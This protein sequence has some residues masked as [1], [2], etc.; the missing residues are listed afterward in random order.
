MD[1]I[2]RAE[3]GSVAS[4]YKN[5]YELIRGLRPHMLQ[6]RGFAAATAPGPGGRTALGG[7]KVFVDNVFVGGTEMLSTIPVPSIALVRHLS[8]SDATIRYG[9][10]M[11]GGAIVIM[12]SPE[13]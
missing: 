10:G 6:P 4:Q 9:S 3:I 12:L 2:S 11:E 5:A 1:E 13:S 8:A 7:V